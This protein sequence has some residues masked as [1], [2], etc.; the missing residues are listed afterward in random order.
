M[1]IF[2][3]WLPSTTKTFVLLILCFQNSFFTLLRRYSQ[4]VLKEQYSKYEVLLLGE[5]IKL[6]FSMFMISSTVLSKL[7]DDQHRPSL[8]SRL[9]WLSCNSGKMFALALGYGVMNVLSYVALRHVGAG[10][11]TIFAQFKTITTATFSTLVLGREY[12]WTRQRALLEL[13]LGAVAF[14]GSAFQYSKEG[15]HVLG[16]SAV[17]IEVTLSGLA[18]IYFEKVIKVDPEKL[19]I[20]ERNF[21]LALGSIPVYF[22]MALF[23]PP[24]A[25]LGTGWSSVTVALSCL[26]AAGGLLVALS[27]KHGDSVLKTLA[28]TGSILLSTVLEYLLLGGPFTGEMG[29]AGGIVVL[30]I[31][32][33]TF[34]RTPIPIDNSVMTTAGTKTDGTDIEGA[35][36]KEE[37][38]EIVSDGKT[39]KE[40]VPLV[41]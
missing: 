27:V 33:Y 31:C 15:N 35:L 29:A 20:W 13:V 21:Q 26:G 4:G 39:G 8:F 23:F 1:G 6:V 11:F 28:T 5:V 2:T 37:E 12:S 24:E 19:N 36:R 22:A 7:K 40:T 9:Y 17:L 32:N 18:S 25:G 30:A 34:D 14:S 3:S 38:G 41:I 10:V 16:T